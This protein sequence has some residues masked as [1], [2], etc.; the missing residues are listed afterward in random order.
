MDKQAKMQRAAL[1]VGGVVVLCVV[2]AFA[3]VA[4]RQ[5]EPKQA[6]AG[7]NGIIESRQTWD[8]AFPA[9][10][11]K[12]APDFTVTDIEGV[13][14]KL[15]DYRGRDVVVV[16]WATWCPACN[17]EIPHLVDLRKEFTR[18]ELVILAISNEPAAH[19]KHFV[20]AKGINYSVVS[21]ADSALP[22][23]Y[24]EVTSI[25]TSFFI[26]K[27]GTVKLAAVG[28]VS[29]EDSRAILKAER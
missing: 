18:D 15:S 23:P 9:W 3:I 14:H 16:F 12:A 20:Q 26:D 25:P 11:G 24:A 13:A 10:A 19:L 28:L 21:V 22:R 8:V 29:L 2:G 4:N 6:A 17:Q 7:L 27:Q 5:P 1:A